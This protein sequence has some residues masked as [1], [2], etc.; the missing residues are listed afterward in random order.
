MEDTNPNILKAAA[1]ILRKR[2]WELYSLQDESELR[3]IFQ[4]VGGIETGINFFTLLNGQVDALTPL[5]K[6]LDNN[7]LNSNNEIL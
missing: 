3:E 6:S 7:F 4:P 5:F 1:C 2:A